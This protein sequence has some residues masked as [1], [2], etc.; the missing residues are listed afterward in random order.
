MTD[1][2]QG[3]SQAQEGLDLDRYLAGAMS[4]DERQEFEDRLAAGT[5][6]SAALKADVN[7]RSEDREA[8]YSKFSAELFA[9]Q[10]TARVNTESVLQPDRAIEIASGLSLGQ[11]LVR[12]VVPLA[13][14]AVAAGVLLV[15]QQQGEEAGLTAESVAP[16]QVQ[17]QVEGPDDAVAEQEAPSAAAPAAVEEERDLAQP[18]P[19]PVAERAVENAEASGAREAG[20]Q[21]R[22]SKPRP[23]VEVPPAPAAD[24]R[25]RRVARRAEQPEKFAAEAKSQSSEVK[26]V[27][28]DDLAAAARDIAAELDAVGNSP[29]VRRP[30][31]QT[32]DDEASA[33]GEIS[34]RQYPVKDE[35]AVRLRFSASGQYMLLVGVAPGSA[36]RALWPRSGTAKLG[37][38]KPVVVKIGV[39]DVPQVAF[40]LVSASPFSLAQLLKKYTI[41][42]SLPRRLP[43]SGEQRSVIVR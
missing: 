28:V 20:Q 26:A 34:L 36:P 43:F 2:E 32:G 1:P 38:A 6:H 3:P 35:R 40:L 42:P 17:A 33:V 19:T 14:I 8:F 29:G 13:G 11:W 9:E 37:G 12:L 41:V 24:K 16:A 23:A 10:V 25:L 15:I 22:P 27:R 21:R 4:R 30:P 18:R 31:V 39:D 5:A 7:Q